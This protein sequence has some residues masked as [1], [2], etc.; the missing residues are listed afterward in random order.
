MYGGDGGWAHLFRKSREYQGTRLARDADREGWFFTIDMWESQRAYDA[1]R[2]SH[3]S[4]Y[5]ELDRRCD[6]MTL[7]ENCIGTFG[8]ELPA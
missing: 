2:K 4:N 3:A 7:Q 1:F 5:A 6:S 8:A